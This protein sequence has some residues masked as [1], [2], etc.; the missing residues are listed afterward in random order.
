M[1]DTLIPEM[2]I[3]WLG[4]GIGLLHFDKRTLEWSL[5]WDYLGIILYKINVLLEPIYISTLVVKALLKY[6]DK[7]V[8]DPKFQVLLLL[9][10]QKK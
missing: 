8:R 10:Y 5:I 3:V 4:Y 1:H 7:S 9:R 2:T 6:V